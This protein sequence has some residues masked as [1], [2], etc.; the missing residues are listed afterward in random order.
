MK[1]F[2]HL[3]Q[4]AAD[5]AATLAAFDTARKETDDIIRAT[6]ERLKL[7][8]EL[9]ADRVAELTKTANDAT[10]SVTVRRVAAAELEKIG[11]QEIGTT[12]EEEAAFAEL[13]EQ[14]EAALRDMRTIRQ[15]VRAAIEAATRRLREIRAEILGNS[16]PGLAP[17]WIEG[18][19][20]AFEKLG[21][22][23]NE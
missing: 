13:M 23:G 5:F 19:R 16:R 3:E 14:Q 2:E 1:E 10:R 17:R 6:D 9:T 18:Q 4:M 21:G 8:R 22:C 20:A 12:A 11:A 7:D 15:N